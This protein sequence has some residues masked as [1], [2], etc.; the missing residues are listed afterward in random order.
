MQSLSEREYI[1]FN[2]CSLMIVFDQLMA[3]YFPSHWFQPCNCLAQRCL[4][5]LGVRDFDLQRIL[6]DP[7]NSIDLLQM[8]TYRKMGYSPSALENPSRIL[9][10]FNE[11]STVSLGDVIIPVQADLVILNVRFSVVEDL[12]PYN[13]ILRWVWLHKMKVILSTYHQMASYLTKARQVDLLGN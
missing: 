5:P 12:S 9:T 3:Y 11:A 7:G 13:V 1:L 2:A 4:D 6:V 10:K 8:S